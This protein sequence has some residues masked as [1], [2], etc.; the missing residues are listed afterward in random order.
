MTD[1]LWFVKTP[2][3]GHKGV[4]L[5]A[6]WATD[7]SRK[8]I[9]EPKKA[10]DQKLTWKNSRHLAT[11]PLVSPPNEVWET[12]AEISWR[13]ITQI[14]VV[15]LIGRAP[16]DIWF[17]QPDLSSDGSSVWNFCACFSDVICNSR[18]CKFYL[19]LRYH[20]RIF[21]NRPGNS[22][23]AG[24]GCQGAWVPEILGHVGW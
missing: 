4:S 6:V 21:E 9:N 5:S 10:L 24:R 19:L 11:V 22:L 15:L 1:L 3:H 14:W 16:W 18:N 8:H 20:D 2:L 7:T 23:T 12:S 17:N 13:I